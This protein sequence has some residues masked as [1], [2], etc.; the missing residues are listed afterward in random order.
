MSNINLVIPKSIYYILS[1]YP[2]FKG[3]DKDNYNKQCQIIINKYKLI[4][5]DYYIPYIKT[6]INSTIQ[7][8]IN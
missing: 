4:P 6:Y 5:K 2:I 3:K 7:L 8:Y 1:K